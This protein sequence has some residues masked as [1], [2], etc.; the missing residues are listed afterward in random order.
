MCIDKANKFFSRRFVVKANRVLNKF[1]T[2]FKLRSTKSL[3]TSGRCVSL[4]PINFVQTLTTDFFCKISNILWV[5]Y[6]DGKGRSWTVEKILGIIIMH[7]LPFSH[8]DYQSSICCKRERIFFLQVF[9]AT[10]FYHY[11]WASFS[12]CIYFR[13]TYDFFG[14]GCCRSAICTMVI[15]TAVESET[16]YIKEM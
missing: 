4:T 13:G 1:I 9:I 8:N 5:V 16:A 3:H 2:E 11:F 10:A 7:T 15:I 12:G 6:S 14:M